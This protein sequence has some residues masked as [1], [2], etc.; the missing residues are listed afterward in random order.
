[1]ALAA[2]LQFLTN[3]RRSAAT[4]AEGDADNASCL[5]AS[6]KPRLTILAERKQPFKTRPRSLFRAYAPV[7]QLDR[8]LVSEAEGQRFESSRGRQQ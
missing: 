3:D 6:A 7:A 4:H 5:K 8:V 2:T 1:M